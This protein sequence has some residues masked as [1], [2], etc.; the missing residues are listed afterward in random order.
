MINFIS[1]LM[2]YY[3]NTFM[4]EFMM[5]YYSDYV[6]RY[7]EYQTLNQLYWPSFPDVVIKDKK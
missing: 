7:G 2:L 3:S 5:Y 4:K 1:Q 6:I